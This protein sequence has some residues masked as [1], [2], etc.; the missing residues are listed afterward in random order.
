MHVKKKG[1]A[2]YLRYLNMFKMHVHL[3]LMSIY[4]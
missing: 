2:L 1:L 4:C 3:I